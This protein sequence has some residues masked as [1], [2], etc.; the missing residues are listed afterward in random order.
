V[1][2][3]QWYW[4]LTHQRPEVADDRDDVDNALGPY[5][6]EDAARNWKQRNEER[7]AA[8]KAQDEA[9]EGEDGVED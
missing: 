6:S 2:T 8:W 9:W 3:T 4:C 5:E 7:D 1:A